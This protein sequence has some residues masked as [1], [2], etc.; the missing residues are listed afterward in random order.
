MCTMIAVVV[1]GSVSTFGAQVAALFS[2][3]MAGL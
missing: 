3:V 2:P 1:A